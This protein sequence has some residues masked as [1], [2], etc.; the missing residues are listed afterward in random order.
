MAQKLTPSLIEKLIRDNKLDELEALTKGMDPLQLRML[1]SDTLGDH[2][3]ENYDIGLE[4][5]LNKAKQIDELPLL[6][7]A[8]MDMYQELPELQLNKLFEKK[9]DKPVKLSIFNQGLDADG[10]GT[11]GY[12]DPNRL[13]QPMIHINKNP[14]LFQ[15]NPRGLILHEADHISDALNKNYIPKEDATNTIKKGLEGAE[16]MFGKH[17]KRGFFELEAL[18]KLTKNKLLGAVPVIG[19][20]LTANEILKSGNVFAADPTG[21]TSSENVGEG[22]DILP[23][24]DLAEKQRYNNR[25]I[26]TRKLLEGE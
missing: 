24:E 15:K 16:E 5:T 3:F 10:T 11:Q 23:Q 6:K 1:M 18:K 13:D 4:K 22:S 17:H 9:I 19:T 26:K 14:E 12:I 20:A 25:M 7:K 2:V 8:S 21:M